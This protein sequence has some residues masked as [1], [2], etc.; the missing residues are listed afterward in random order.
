MHATTLRPRLRCGAAVARYLPCAATILALLLALPAA[1]PGGLLQI[2]VT[3]TDGHILSGP[4]SC[5]L[6]Q[7]PTSVQ[8]SFTLNATAPGSYG[9][10]DVM[11]ASL[12]F[13]DGAWNAGDLQSFNT[14]VGKLN[15][16]FPVKSLSYEL[17]PIDTPTT[18]GRIATNYPLYIYGIDLASGLEFEYQY[19]TSTQTLTPEPC[20]LSSATFGLLFFLAMCA[21]RRKRLTGE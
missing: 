19:D 11:Q 3:Y 1:A 5:G 9:I 16:E 2:D 17:K 8:A 13:G 15:D 12:V 21:R 20:G 6:M 4:L 18:S 10:G 14:T 7:L